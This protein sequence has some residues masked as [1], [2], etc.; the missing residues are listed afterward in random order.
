MNG[1]LFSPLL[2]P[3]LLSWLIL[4]SVF[5]LGHGDLVEFCE[6]RTRGAFYGTLRGFTATL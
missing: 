2:R 6:A 5:T 4:S 1:V 3:P